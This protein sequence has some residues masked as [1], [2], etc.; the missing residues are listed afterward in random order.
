MNSR[1]KMQTI[2]KLEANED[3]STR[4]SKFIFTNIDDMLMLETLLEIHCNDLLQLQALI[5]QFKNSC[6]AFKTNANEFTREND[7]GR[8]YKE[9][10]KSIINYIKTIDLREKEYWRKNLE[11][12]IVFNFV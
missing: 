9:K 1:E 8:S 4:S 5:D 10:T 2:I 3:Y 7:F 12:R 6:N 11:V